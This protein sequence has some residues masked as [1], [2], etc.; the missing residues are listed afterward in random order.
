MVQYGLLHSQLLKERLVLDLQ[1]KQRWL[2]L[3]LYKSVSR[4]DFG[5]AG[6]GIA[7]DMMVRE[8][9]K[10]EGGWQAERL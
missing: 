4:M 7:A 2:E 1:S 5:T 6:L 9:G 8:V 3:T 10:K